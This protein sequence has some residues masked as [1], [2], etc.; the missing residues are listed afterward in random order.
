MYQCKLTKISVFHAKPS[1][2][3]MHSKVHSQARDFE[4]GLI[5][6]SCYLMI[7][8]NQCN[9]ELEWLMLPYRSLYAL[10]M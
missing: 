7:D 4:L 10:T 9:F 8:I 5:K 2:C 6:R 1:S 3:A